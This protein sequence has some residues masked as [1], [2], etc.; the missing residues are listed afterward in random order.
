M[1]APLYDQHYQAVV[2]ADYSL[3][4]GGPLSL[5][6]Q[7]QY[8]RGVAVVVMAIKGIFNLGFLREAFGV[9]WSLVAY[10]K[11]YVQL[12]EVG[13]RL[14]G[15]TAFPF[16]NKYAKS[17]FVIGADGE[18]L[19]SEYI[20]SRDYE[21]EHSSS[22]EDSD[23]EPER[24]PDPEPGSPIVTPMLLATNPSLTL[25]LSIHWMCPMVPLSFDSVTQLGTLIMSR[26]N[27]TTLTKN[28]ISRLLS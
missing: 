9:D 3:A 21:D 12:T 8:H 26:G 16:D 18:E 20:D 4:D 27:K 22:E 11:R 23:Y 17:H 5:F 24:P 7:D 1:L 10:T 28:Y 19:F 13:Q 15:E 14:L 25:A 2:V 6:V